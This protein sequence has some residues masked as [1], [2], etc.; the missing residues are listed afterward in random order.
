MKEATD[1]YEFIKT[2]ESA[3]SQP[4]DINGWEWS[5]KQHIKTSFYYMHGRLLNGNDE[6]TPVRNITRRLIKL[7][8]TEQDVDVKDIVLYVDDPDSYHLSFLIKKYHDDVYVLENDLDTF[9]DDW[10]ND[11]T[12]Y[13]GGLIKKGKDAKPEVIDLQSIAFCDQTDMLKGPIAF[14]HFYN[15]AELYDMEEMGWGQE[16]NGAT[17]S[18]QSLIDLADASRRNDAQQ[19]VENK[20]PGKYI[21]IYEVHGVLPE[22][23]L[24]DGGSDTKYVRQF[25]IIGFYKDAKGEKNGITLFRKKETK[26]RLKLTL[27]DKIYSRALGFGGAEEL[28]EPQVWTTYSE[29]R[30]KDLLDAASKVVN[31]T[32]NPDLAKRN[33]VK[34]ISNQQI[35]DVTPGTKGLWQAD[36]YPR[37]IG[38]F[39]KSVMTWEEHAQGTAFAT[40]PLLGEEAPSGTPFR[41][42][43]RQV[44]QG[45]GP[46]QKEKGKYA[47][48]LEFV[49]RDW[50]IPDIEEKICEG[51][52]FLSELS[53]EE[54]TYVGNKLAESLAN[55]YVADKI[56]TVGADLSNLN[57][58]KDLYKQKVL[59][60]FANRGNKHFLEVLK[61]EF[62]KKPLKVK[63]NIA[64]KQKDLAFISDKLTNI[65]RQIIANPQ[66]FIQL[67]Q[68]DGMSQTFNDLLEY[69]GLSPV[70][71]A[72]L[73][74]QQPQVAPQGA[75]PQPSPMQPVAQPQ[76][77]VV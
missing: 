39:E 23:Y 19:G 15:P 9:I 41:A 38:L 74:N 61:G 77:A 7:Q 26:Q 58:E 70:R 33:N 34:D 50:I 35:L 1:I 76:G 56:L 22:A 27:R 12:I 63:I 3:F 20:T 59:Q 47:K 31:L 73:M 14:K 29:I 51:T 48:D 17:A 62:K 75:Q 36:T 37:N 53:T 54:M 4:I 21:E 60:E 45:K 6:D 32:D 68:I 57:Q 71:F 49:Y 55:E 5:M 11:R 44:I 24:E 28:F 46:H 66:G 13:G 10:L 42:Q 64:G 52:K 40:N 8:K 30:I 16:S 67:M 43:E 72:G 25:Q 65:F 69:G 2:E 18:I